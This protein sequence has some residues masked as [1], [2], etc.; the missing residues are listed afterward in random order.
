MVAA[1]VAGEEGAAS[2]AASG[3]IDS[4]GKATDAF[5]NGTISETTLIIILVVAAVVLVGALIAWSYSRKREDSDS[6][7]GE[8]YE[9]AGRGWRGVPAASSRRLDAVMVDGLSPTASYPPN[10]NSATPSHQY[11]QQLDDDRD[12]ED[13][14]KLLGGGGSRASL[15][16]EAQQ[17]GVGLPAPLTRAARRPIDFY[18]VPLPVLVPMPQPS[19][20][21]SGLRDGAGERARWG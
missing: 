5:G 14:A 10:L 2:E 9:Y 17:G 1:I 4:A 3:A 11:R 6:S 15:D 7:S 12:P 20:L 19:P 18:G 13:T 16:L 21:S 8:K